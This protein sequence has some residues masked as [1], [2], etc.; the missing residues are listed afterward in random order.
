M[1]CI[2]DAVV[3]LQYLFNLI[4]HQGTTSGKADYLNHLSDP[5]SLQQPRPSL[6]NMF[7]PCISQPQMST[8]S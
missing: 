2:A 3:E 8:C 4:R 5:G 1:R 7:L 6:E